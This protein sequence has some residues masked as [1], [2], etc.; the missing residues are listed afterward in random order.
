M[1]AKKNQQ[2]KNWAEAG[3]NTHFQSEC[4]RNDFYVSREFSSKYLETLKF[5]FLGLGLENRG[6][7]ML[8]SHPLDHY[9]CQNFGSF[10][11]TTS[12]CD[13]RLFTKVKRGLIT[14]KAFENSSNHQKSH[15]QIMRLRVALLGSARS[16]DSTKG[17][18][19]IDKIT[20]YALHC[21]KTIYIS[22]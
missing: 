4:V 22:P 8:L 15:L 21:T 16:F 12:H 20:I 14:P 10:R 13:S 5:Y 17:R 19:Q 7:K 9:S 2:V 1:I 11:R 3:F 6:L 18:F